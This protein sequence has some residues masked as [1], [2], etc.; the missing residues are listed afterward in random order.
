M[1]D[2]G[3]TIEDTWQVAICDLCHFVVDRAKVIEHLTTV[4]GLV[5]QSH[6]SVLR[7][8]RMLRLRPHLAIIWDDTIEGQLDESDDEDQGAQLFSPPAFR[9]GSAPLQGIAVKDGFKCRV[10]A[11][12]LHHV[13]VTTQEG[14]RTHYKRNHKGQ[15]VEYPEVKVQA[16][17]GRSRSVSQLRYVQVKETEDQDETTI[18][19][20]GIPEDIHSVPSHNSTL[21]DKRDLNLF[22]S[23][24]QV[25]PLLETLDLSDLGPLLYSPQDRAG[26]QPMLGKVMVGERDKYAVTYSPLYI[27]GHN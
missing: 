26:F 2:L 21:T 16:F 12:K 9:P 7:V 13:C 24:F 1:A 20:F 3:F 11:Q 22:G 6:D 8:L 25:Y 18:A 17:Y 4:H 27:L 23:K 10:C 5:V 15:A 19:A 14:M